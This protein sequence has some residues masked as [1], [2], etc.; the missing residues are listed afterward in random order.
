MPASHLENAM[1]FT[2]KVNGTAHSVDVDGDT[3]LLW[4]LRDVRGMTGTKDRRHNK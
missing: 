3:P 2:I 1:A 4:V